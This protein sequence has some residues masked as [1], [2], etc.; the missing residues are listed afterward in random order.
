MCFGVTEANVGLDTTRLK[1]RAVKDGNKYVINGAKCWTTTAQVSDKIMLLARTD[2]RDDKNPAGGLSM[3]YTDLDR[4][5]VDVRRIEKMGRHDHSSAQLHA[6][7]HDQSLN[8]GQLLD[9]DFDPEVTPRDHDPV[10]GRQ[11]GV[12]PFYRRG[13]LDFR[14]DRGTALT[15]IAGL[16]HILGALHEAQRQPIHAQFADEFQIGAVLVG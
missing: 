3:F 6:T 8:D 1:T 9:V 2:E 10:R 16:L 5:A 4:S 13:F 7:L 14:Q 11:D 15:Q 12:E